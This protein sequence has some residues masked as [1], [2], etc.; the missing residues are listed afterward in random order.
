MDG[1]E[2][3][4]KKAFCYFWLF[5]SKQKGAKKW[6]EKAWLFKL[7]VCFCVTSFSSLLIYSCE[8]GV[9][10]GEA[11]DEMNPSQHSHVPVCNSRGNRKARETDASRQT[12][13][14]HRR[15]ARRR[16]LKQSS[17]GTG[18]LLQ[19]EWG[20]IRQALTR[21]LVRHLKLS[22]NN[23]RLA[24]VAFRPH[25]IPKTPTTP[26]YVWPALQLATSQT[27]AEEIFCFIVQRKLL[28]CYHVAFCLIFLWQQPFKDFED[29]FNS[30]S[31][32]F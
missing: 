26:W 23:E 2:R 6:Y 28:K 8:G 1:S 29:W 19:V 15:D 13:W 10:Y 3:H 5:F 30:F 22:G 24:I 31:W 7:C 18:T 9:L 32:F 21:A 20:Y 25:T 16:F 12:T 17:P 4:L 27:T 14:Q 11:A